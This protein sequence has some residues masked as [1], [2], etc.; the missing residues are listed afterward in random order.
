MANTLDTV[1]G[2]H[3][4][5]NYDTNQRTVYVPE[6]M[7]AYAH[8]ALFYKL[9]DY[10]VNL[11]A[12]RTGS[13]V[14][15][16]P[17]DPDPNIQTLG[18]RDLWLPQLFMD[19]Q[20]ITITAERH[21][22][23]IQLHKYDD[24]I[25]YWSEQGAAGL[26]AIMR[27]RV[28]PNMVATLDILAR[29]AFL[30][31]FAPM[32][33]GSKSDFGA[34]LATD[35]FDPG[36]GR[37]VWLWADYTPDPVNHPVVGLVSPA[38]TYAFKSGAGSTEWMGR[39]DYAD[40]ARLLNYEI[41]QYEGVRY[42]Q[43]PIC[44]LWNCGPI[45]T[46]KTITAAVAQGD[47]APDPSTSKV[48][49]VY[50]TGQANQTHYIQL[51][52]SDGIRAGDTV[53]LHRARNAAA[54]TTGVYLGVPY[55][56]YQNITRRVVSVDTSTERITLNKPILVD[57]YETAVAGHP[58]T[59]YGWVTKARPVHVGVFLKGPR[60]VVSGVLQPPATYTPPPIDD[61]Q[62][63]YRFSW[64]AYLKYQIMNPERFEVYFYAGA[65][66]R[67]GEVINL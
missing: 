30:E 41:G 40:P 52:T 8:S 60:G 53:T 18:N 43:H 37:D 33:A 29:N 56:N 46:Q 22:G 5:A 38:A 16:K 63:I 62:S 14:F 23:K 17:I 24:M 34:L 45:I 13:M 21:G 19:S 39:L 11:A 49:G 12:Q 36:V 57:W 6:L 59:I 26:R 31:H 42:A 66:R 48:D 64:D 67:L 20:N 1:F 4:W 47:G 54:S 3:P 58:S 61:T 51:S 44:T 2:D 9:V 50:A 10:G 25:T 65:Q 32:F 7:E 28:A 55:N 15:T 27:K 35:T